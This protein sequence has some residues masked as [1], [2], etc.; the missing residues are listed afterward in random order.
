MPMRCMFYDDN[1]Q[2]HGPGCKRKLEVNGCTYI[3]PGDPEWA[4]ARPPTRKYQAGRGRGRGRGGLPGGDR[5]FNTVASG[6]TWGGNSSSWG[7]PE[8]S[9]SANFAPSSSIPTNTPSGRDSGWGS[10]S[11]WGGTTGRGDPASG[12]DGVGGNIVAAGWGSPR[13]PTDAR[14]Q[15]KPA[16]S[17]E[18]S[19]P[20]WVPPDQSWGS[21]SG[22]WGQ[23]G[24]WGDS[25][26]AWTNARSAWS[27]VKRMEEPKA[28]D[29]GWGASISPPK[30]SESAGW[31]S[32]G[33]INS[34][35]GHA[36]WSS[37]STPGSQAGNAGWGSSASQNRQTCDIDKDPSTTKNGEGWHSTD[38]TTSSGSRSSFTAPRSDSGWVA[39]N[40]GKPEQSDVSSASIQKSARFDDSKSRNVVDSNGPQVSPFASLLDHSSAPSKWAYSFVNFGGSVP[41]AASPSPSTTTEHTERSSAPSIPSE[42]RA[43]K[44]YPRNIGHAVLYQQDVMDAETQRDKIKQLQKSQQFS[45]VGDKGRDRLESIRHDQHRTYLQVNKQLAHA[46]EN[47]VEHTVRMGPKDTNEERQ[48]AAEELAVYVTQAKGWLESI[49]PHAIQFQE[50]TNMAQTCPGTSCDVRAVPPEQNRHSPSLDSELSARLQALEAASKANE[51]YLEKLRLSTLSVIED[52]ANM[53]ANELQRENTQAIEFEEGE[54]LPPEAQL[55]AD[56]SNLYA[57]FEHGDMSHELVSVRGELEDQQRY[58]Q[59]LHELSNHTLH[60]QDQNQLYKHKIH[61]P[62]VEHTANHAQAQSAIEMKNSIKRLRM[63]VEEL[64]NNSHTLYSLP[65]QPKGPSTVEVVEILKEAIMPSIE[66]DLQKGIMGIQEGLEQSFHAQ[67]DNIKLGFEVNVQ[68]L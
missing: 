40:Q 35:P 57:S 4:T 14:V 16:S 34:Q 12:G 7:N 38:Q 20:G 63:I 13:V 67:L 42:Q 32:S 62:M 58:L 22:D 27:D 44:N 29:S 1:G 45:S 60:I 52:V 59:A 30:Q 5:G 17:G 18:A 64:D 68:S 46:I 2:P 39:I 54:V 43:R 28:K 48:A 6:S 49:W 3:H 9:S 10:S 51:S 21:S 31:G 8:S 66:A 36:S 65:H 37:W 11:A 50:L 24:G 55:V 47:L 56:L 25:A 15:S 41:R 19:A 53:R 23:T 61:M 33:T 26:N